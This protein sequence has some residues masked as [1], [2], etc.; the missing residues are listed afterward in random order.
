[1]KTYR[2]TLKLTDASGAPIVKDVRGEGHEFSGGT[3]LNIYSSPGVH[4]AIFPEGEFAA[5]EIIPDED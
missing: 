1:M 3:N 4:V 2:V 5:I